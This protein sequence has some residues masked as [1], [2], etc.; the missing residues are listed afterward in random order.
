MLSALE[1]DKQAKIIDVGCGNGYFLQK[2]KNNGHQNL[3]GCD[4]INHLTDKTIH[5]KKGNVEKLPYEDN[6]FD[7]VIC[8]HTIEHVLNPHLAIKELKRIARRKLIITVPKQR[9][10]YYTVDIHV[11]F[12]ETKRELVNLLNINN[13]T[14]ETLNGDFCFVGILSDS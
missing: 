9:Y 13:Y 2:L 12:F 5:F 10:Y 1:K 7:I 4:I 11:N 8:N 14:C 6:E 3:S